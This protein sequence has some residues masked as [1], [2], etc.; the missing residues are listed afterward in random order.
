MVG[1][2]DQIATGG[3]Q[4][5]AGVGFAVPIGLVSASLPKLKA[6]QQVSHA[7]LGV[8]TGGDGEHPRRDAR[9]PDARRAGRRRGAARG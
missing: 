6:G 1:I 5:N 7:Y 8:A 4:Q 2:A 3:T 9:R